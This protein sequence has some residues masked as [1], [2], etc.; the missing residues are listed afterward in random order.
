MAD[1]AAKPT[2]A[3]LTEAVKVAG[4]A[5]ATLK[6]SGIKS[7]AEFDAALATLL[8]AKALLPATKKNKGKPKGK[9]KGDKKPKKPKAPEKSWEEKHAI[10]TANLAAVQAIVAEAE[11]SGDAKKIKNAAKKLKKAEKG[12]KLANKKP[13]G[14]RFG[15]SKAKATLPSAAAAKTAYVNTTP[16]GEKKDMTSDMAGAFFSCDGMTEYS[17]ILMILLNDYILLSRIYIIFLFSI[18]V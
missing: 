9:K 4:V 3:E 13:K 5:V 14:E 18:I 2:V 7:G 6:K 8:A 1:A 17:N 10:A 15:K 16:K 11:A 12:L